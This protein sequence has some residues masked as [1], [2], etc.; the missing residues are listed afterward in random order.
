MPAPA[1]T[2][3]SN[4][5]VALK[6][7]LAE[8]EFVAGYDAE[9]ASVAVMNGDFLL[10]GKRRDNGKWTLPGGHLNPGEAPHAGGLR[11]LFEETGIQAHQLSTLGERGV[12]TDDGRFVMVYAY[13]YPVES[14]VTAKFDPDREFV[15]FRWFDTR[16][17][18]PLYVMRNLHVTRNF[19]LA[20]L[21]L[22][23]GRTIEGNVGSHGGVVVRYTRTGKPVYQSHED[24]INKFRK[25]KPKISDN[26]V[27]HARAAIHFAFGKA[28]PIPFVEI[29]LKSSGR[30]HK[31]LR[32]YKS[33]SG[34]WVY[35]YHEGE[36]HGRAIPDEAI[37]HLHKLANLGDEHAKALLLTTEEHDK[38]KLDVLRELGDLGDKDAVHHL[39]KLGIDHKADKQARDTAE[40]E[41]HL[42]AE[43]NSN[44]LTKQLEG[45][46][47]SSLHDA[48]RQTVE[49]KVFAYLRGHPG[50]PQEVRLRENRITLD[51]V[52]A[53]VSREDTVKG[54]LRALHEALKPIDQAHVGLSS[55]NPDVQTHGSYGNSAYNNV[56]RV[57]TERHVIPAEAATENRRTTA[58]AG[59]SLELDAER[60]APA[61]RGLETARREAA[62]RSERE[63]VEREAREARERTERA[64]RE[65]REARERA[66][67]EAMEAVTR[68]AREERD[69]RD[70]AEA[71]GIHQESINKMATYFGV[72]IPS[73]EH[74]QLAK[75]IQKMW[76]KNFKFELFINHLNP[77]ASSPTE[78]KV[79]RDFL[80]GLRHARAM[81][82][83]R[84]FELSVSFDVIEKSSGRHITSAHRGVYRNADGSI[85]WANGSFSR[86]NN[87]DLKR[88]PGMARGLYMGVE[89]FLKE[90]TAD[91]TGAAKENTKV[92]IG[93][94]ANGGFGN[95][96]K[97]ALVWAKHCFDWSGGDGG[98]STSWRQRWTRSVNEY[99]TRIGMDSAHKTQLL[100]KISAAQYPHQFVNTGFV[101]TKAQAIQATGRREL[102]FDFDQIFENKGYCDIGDLIMI[103]SGTSW[104]AE[105]YLNRTTG[106]AGALNAVRTAYYGGTATREEPT[107]I[108]SRASVAS[109]SAP[110]PTPRAAAP[111]S[112]SAEPTVSELTSAGWTVS[113]DRQTAH[114]GPLATASAVIRSDNS[115]GAA[116]RFILTTSTGQSRHST[117]REAVNTANTHLGRVSPSPASATAPRTTGSRPGASATDSLVRIFLGNWSRQ[118]AR[119]EYR[120]TLSDRRMG[121]VLALNDAALREFMTHSRPHLAP[122][123][124]RRLEEAIRA[125]GRRVA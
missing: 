123:A 19:T 125:A 116:S 9:V 71:L 78:L 98:N 108:A 118:N 43:R 17:G 93:S 105:N 83:A 64:E 26:I 6:D 48:I 82:S 39:K 63:R 58:N 100:D 110:A 111:P 49:Q 47:L 72:A 34:N 95:G 117:L 18:L 61:A 70:N 122:A 115:A 28:D 30:P 14:K 38:G 73:H 60:H 41:K 84:D 23:K 69:R 62:E 12:V 103:D 44:P 29:M 55:S 52:M 112:S 2:R 96:Y 22:Q 74:P 124:R 90:L 68:A 59:G 65:A 113:P 86:A 75:N 51:S 120:I 1:M 20:C 97:G 106:R 45:V 13:Y 89:N 88:Y 33:P 57:L 3:A 109:P 8:N 67:R 102:D 21:G 31:Y 87:Q 46:D 42:F 92:T 77:R 79:S 107:H 35:V 16:R 81:R 4:Y 11:E 119:G 121:R 7:S 56:L 80:D 101:V 104:S 36:A 15:L 37:E 54:S 27:G 94:C 50:V 85:H 66:E 99:A 40:I 10:M 32:K 24:R 76:G 5:T 114:I 25:K 91:W 53:P